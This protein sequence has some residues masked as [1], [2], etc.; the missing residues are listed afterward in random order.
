M[1]LFWVYKE[2]NDHN[3][4]EVL[5]TT[6]WGI[7]NNRNEVQHS[8][9]SKTATVIVNNAC[10]YM[11]EYK[12]T[13][14]LPASRPTQTPTSWK[15]PPTDWYKINV[16]SA[17]F[18]ETGQCGIGVIVRNDKGE[19][20]GAHSKK[21][22]FPLGALEAEVKAMECGIIFAWELGLRQVIIEGDSQVVIQALECETLAPISINR[23]SRGQKCGGQL[24]L[25]GKQA[26]LN[27]AT[28]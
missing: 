15:P 5:T 19:I 20:M 21:L 18:K 12:Q 11:E 1:D 22:Y 16:V 8:G 25:H 13:M 9:T 2:E 28:T 26:S 24:S 10:K 27:V 3:E 4:L 6:A 17:V 7:W 14:D 23:S